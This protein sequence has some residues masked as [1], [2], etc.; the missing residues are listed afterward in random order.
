MQSDEKTISAL[1]AQAHNAEADKRTLQRKLAA[2]ERRVQDLEKRLTEQQAAS[3]ERVRSLTDQLSQEMAKVS[4]MMQQLVSYM[5]GKGDVTLA[6]TIH[7]TVVAGIREEVRQEFRAMLDEKDAM[8]SEKDAR[9]AALEALVNQ[10][11]DGEPPL[12]TIKKLEHQNEDLRRTTYGQKTE[13]KY[14]GRNDMTPADEADL[15]G[16]DVPESTFDVSEEEF[17]EVMAIIN[18]AR[19]NAIKSNGRKKGQKVPHRFQPLKASAREIIIEPKDKPEGAT[20][21]EGK[22]RRT[23]RIVHHPAWVEYI[24]FVCPKYEKDHKYYQ[25]KAPKHSMGKCKADA[26]ILSWIIYEHLVKHVTLGEIEQD[27][28][29]MGLNIAHATLCHWMELAAEKLEPLDEPLHQEIITSG[30]FHSDESTLQVLD[31]PVGTKED[32]EVPMHYYIRWIYDFIA[33]GSGLT[34]YWFYDQGRRTQEAVEDYVK[35]IM[36]KTYIH[37]DG[38]KMYEIYNAAGIIMRVACAVH[39]RRPFWKLKETSDDAARIVY[40]FDEVFRKE[41]RWNDEEGMTNEKRR[42][43]RWEEVYPILHEMKNI[44]DRMEKELDKETE[45]DLVRAVNFALKEYPQ[46]LRYLDDGKLAFSNNIC[47]LQMRQIAIYRNQSYFLGSV[48]SAKRFARLVSLTQSAKNCKR[49][50]QK[51][52]HDILNRIVV[53]VEDELVS[54]LPHKWV[55]PVTIPLVY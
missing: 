14:N 20:L 21:C 35:G 53:D 24:C 52:F 49:N 34:Q 33:P 7:E 39:V 18:S 28:K 10:D 47:E 26:S 54:M 55:E 2:S 8:L 42:G 32:E 3:E 43:R 31:V 5:M 12:I 27:L 13:G 11:H 17:T 4:D 44:L 40:L 22:E 23:Y 29:S 48:K 19:K 15:N 1:T 45:P 41:R 51:Y 25:A 46:L 30:N 9:I 6:G 37:T 38:A 50:V 36:E 16:E